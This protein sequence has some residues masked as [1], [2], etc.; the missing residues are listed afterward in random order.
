MDCTHC[1]PKSCRNLESCGAEKFDPEVIK[2]IYRDPATQAVVQAAAALVDNGRAGS[3]SR[4]RETIEFAK[5]MK[6]KKIGLAYCYGME[7]DAEAVGVIFREHGLRLTGVSCT[8]GG[9]SQD[10]VNAA[11]CTHKVSCNPVGQAA[12]FNAEGTDL[13]IMMGI[14][15][16]HDILLQRELQCDVTT[17]AVK[18]RVF[19][20]DPMR[21][22]RGY[23]DADPSCIREATSVP[24]MNI[25]PDFSVAPQL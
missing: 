23:P 16:G 19:D 9:V 2:E 20:N 8:V 17:F 3:L 6:Y 13:V 7:H 4:L 1:A 24:A 21:I 18:D 5:S 15:L 10:A 25:K 14:C 22:L 12:Q 11:S